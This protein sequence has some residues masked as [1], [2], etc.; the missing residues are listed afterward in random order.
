MEQNLS[1]TIPS[2][3]QLPGDSWDYEL[4]TEGVRLSKDVAGLTCEIGLRRGGGSK[5]I[6]DAIAEYCPDK[7]HIAIDPYG[8]IP[9]EHKEGHIVT[10]DYTNEMY[11]DAMVNLFGYARE[12]K[13]HVLF[14]PLEDTEF[15]DRFK[16]FVPVYDNKKHKEFKYSFVHFDGPHSLESVLIEV[17]FFLGKDTGRRG[18]PRIATGTC[19]CFDDVNKDDLYYEHILV[20]NYLKKESFKLIKWADRKA[21]YQYE[22]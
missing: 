10:L 11:V 5:Y 19:F 22:G 16:D 15:F 21:L 9:Y 13:V 8:N 17:D 7:T 6:I 4:L 3:I 12:K 2:S 14:F 20:D 1:T 18:T